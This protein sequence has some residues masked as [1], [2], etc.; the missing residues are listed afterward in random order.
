MLFFLDCLLRL[1]DCPCVY[2]FD[3]FDNG[4]ISFYCMPWF[5]VWMRS[6]HVEIRPDP[7]LAEPNDRVCFFL[8]N[9]RGWDNLA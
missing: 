4:G 2:E 7:S 6:V 5:V 1:L 8:F 9:I 3:D